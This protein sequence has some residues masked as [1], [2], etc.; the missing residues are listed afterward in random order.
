[1][2]CLVGKWIVILDKRFTN[3]F[4]DVQKIKQEIRASEA[5]TTVFLKIHIFPDVK[6]LLPEHSDR[7]YKSP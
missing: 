6:I 7:R 1:M 5:L 4:C 3:H 2:T